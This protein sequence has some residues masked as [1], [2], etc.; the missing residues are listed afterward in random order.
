[1]PVCR[2]CKYDIT[3]KTRKLCIVRFPCCST[4]FLMVCLQSADNADLLS[5]VSEEVA[6]EIAKKIRR[7]PHCPLTPPPGG[8]RANTS[9][10]LIFLETRIV[11]LHFVLTVW[12]YL[13]SNFSGGLR[14]TKVIDFGTNRKYECDFLLVYHSNLGPVS[15]RFRDIRYCRFFCNPPLFHPDFGGVPVGPDRRC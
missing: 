5:K 10:C 14:K 15:H 8:T 3:A 1:M 4:A 6:T 11:D 12:V 7:Q 13:H 2:L 9:T